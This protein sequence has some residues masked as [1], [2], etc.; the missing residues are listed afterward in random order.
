MKRTLVGGFAVAAMT[1]LGAAPA[2]A[3]GH[4]QHHGG[5]HKP[6][7]HKPG[8]SHQGGSPL[9][10]T[11]VPPP[12]HNHQ[13]GVPKPHPCVC[14]SPTPPHNH[15]GGHHG[16]PPVK[17]HPRPTPHERSHPPVVTPPAHHKS[18]KHTT[19]VQLTTSHHLTALPRTG[20]NVMVYGFAGGA[21]VA[22]GSATI[23]ASGFRRHTKGQS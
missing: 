2:L 22:L 18:R 23:L 9:P 14:K 17:V 5:H 8:H 21:L 10:G 11:P 1:L 6:A 12:P 7:E 3:C 4:P 13:G 15:Q 20:A 16:K 19:R